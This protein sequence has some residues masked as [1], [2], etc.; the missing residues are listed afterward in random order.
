MAKKER[1][2]N[3]VQMKVKNSEDKETGNV[4]TMEEEEKK[5]NKE[6]KETGNMRTVEEEVTMVKL[7]SLKNRDEK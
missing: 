4:R 2:E 5:V 3:K 6:D 1:K 7:N